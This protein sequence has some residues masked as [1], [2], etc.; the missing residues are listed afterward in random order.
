MREKRK[1]PVLKHGFLL[2]RDVSKAA[3]L[4][5]AKRTRTIAQ[6]GLATDASDREIVCKAWDRR[7]TIVTANGDDFI[8][9]ITSFLNQT[10]RSDCHDM[11]GL[12]ILPNGYENQKQLLPGIERKLRLGDERLTWADVAKK[13]CCVRVKKRGNP[14]VTRFSRCFYCRKRGHE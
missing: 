8:R 5:P 2:D 10:K 7:L 4:F 1:D 6:V 12:I 11:Y 13:D 9:E 3:S 14:K